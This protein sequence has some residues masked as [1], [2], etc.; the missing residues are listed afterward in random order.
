M[1]NPKTLLV[2]FSLLCG[3]I[4]FAQDRTISGKVVSTKENVGVAGVSIT[5]KGTNTGTSTGPD[6]AFS[7]TAPAGRVTLQLSSVGYVTKEHVVEAS[8]NNIVIDFRYLYNFHI[9]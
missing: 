2:S 3:A 6:G 5:V 4:A 8:Q 9:F 1:L 7:L